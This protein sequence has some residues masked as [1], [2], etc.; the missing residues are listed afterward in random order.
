MNDEELMKR[1][2]RLTATEEKTLRK[3]LKAGHDW[4][5]YYQGQHTVIR[6]DKL[7][8]LMKDQKKLRQL[9]QEKDT[10][11]PKYCRDCGT[12]IKTMPCDEEPTYCPRCDLE[13][14]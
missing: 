9:R 8:L 1:I 6:T 3:L 14:I 12:P 5:N 10:T 4:Q 7:A 2:I 11:P 13:H